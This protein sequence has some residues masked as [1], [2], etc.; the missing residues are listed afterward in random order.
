MTIK[1]ALNRNTDIRPIQLFPAISRRLTRSGALKSDV[2]RSARDS[3]ANQGIF[4]AI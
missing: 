3:I 2:P 4:V 1:S